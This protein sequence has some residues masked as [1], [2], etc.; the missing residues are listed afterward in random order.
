MSDLHTQLH[1]Y[2]ESTIERVDVDDVVAAVSAE[3]LAD[4]KPTL[5]L[6]PVWVAAG[7]A[8]LVVLLVGVPLLFVGDDASTTGGQPTPTTMSVSSTAPPTTQP[9]SS[10]TAP[11]ATVSALPGIPLAE[12]VPG[13]ADTIVMFATPRAHTVIRWEPSEPTPDIVLTVRGLFSPVGLDVSAGWLAEIS[14]DGALLVYPVPTVTGQRATSEVAATEV[15][16]AI[17]HDTEAG[18]LAYLACPEPSS[19]TAALFTLDITDPTA[20]PMAIRTF[21]QGCMGDDPFLEEYGVENVWLNIWRSDGVV[22]QVFNGDTFE[23]VLIDVDGTEIPAE[24][25]T[26]MLPEGPDGQRLNAEGII[27]SGEAL[28]YASWSP[29]GTRVAL[30]IS[31][32][33]PDGQP[34]RILRVVDAA[35][36]RSVVETPDLADSVIT[37]TL[38]W[39]SDGR[40]VL[41]HAWYYPSDSASEGVDEEAGSASLGLYDTAAN[42]ITMVPLDGVVDEIRIP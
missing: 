11:T 38:V 5:R 32:P 26:M 23:G 31:V 17:W 18:R 13:F 4:P 16:S 20:E 30:L 7:A 25:D 15:H 9:L 22:L 8:L 1:D 12:A 6:R 35:T 41:Y 33:N 40:F 2:V 10:A 36:G 21:D 37:G 39:S 29:D 14:E 24:S 19:G 3:R 34:G 28:R 27:A 42:T